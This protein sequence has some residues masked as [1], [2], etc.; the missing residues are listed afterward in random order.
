MKKLTIIWDK[1]Q[2]EFARRYVDDLPLEELLDIGKSR[3]FY[4]G[5]KN[6]TA[7][8]PLVAAWEKKGKIVDTRIQGNPERG[9]A[10]KILVFEYS[11]GDLPEQRVAYRGEKISDKSSSFPLQY[12]LIVASSGSVVVR[13]FDEPAYNG[14]KTKISELYRSSLNPY[15]SGLESEVAEFNL[16]LA[17]S[18][19]EFGDKKAGCKNAILTFPQTYTSQVEEEVQLEIRILSEEGNYENVVKPVLE[20][21][22]YSLV[23]S[24]CRGGG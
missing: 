19:M 6:G 11:K 5:P 12:H 9:A 14:H 1:E 3:G 15:Y 20:K 21:L 16:G 8:R 4:D 7:C 10:T 22:G 24:P 18:N 13:E 2:D 17:I 23:E